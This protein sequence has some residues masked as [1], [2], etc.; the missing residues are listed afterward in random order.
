M[1]GLNSLGWQ[2]HDHLKEHRPKMFRELK[3]LGTLKVTVLRMQ[4]QASERKPV[5]HP[6][7]SADNCL[8]YYAFSAFS[9]YTG[10]QRPRA[11]IQTSKW[12]AK[13]LDADILPMVKGGGVLIS[14]PH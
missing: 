1:T 3:R 9:R 6:I 13:Q 14:P 10:D 11:A 12:H 5:T 4:E 7:P 2:I 8:M